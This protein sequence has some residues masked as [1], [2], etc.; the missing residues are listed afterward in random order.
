[1]GPGTRKQREVADRERLILDVAA[2][3]LVE[4]G[5]LGLT[6]DRIAEATEYSK[7]T[8]YQHFPNKEDI[9]AQLAI[10]T[11][12]RRAALFRRAA[13]FQGNS[14]ER[15]AA[16][17][18]A[19]GLF[20]R[21]NPLHSRCEPMLRAHSIREKTNPDRLVRLE[22]CEFACMDVALGVV[23]E[24]MAA[25][26]LAGD[27]ETLPQTIMLGLWALASGFHALAIQED[28]DLESKLGISDPATTLFTCYDHL[29]DGFGWKP[30]STEWDYAAT[31]ERVRREV[32]PDEFQQA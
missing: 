15:M 9:L 4:R 12:E 8:I 20:V 14:R 30:L 19:E 24:G 29:L 6:M 26:D 3:M 13:A 10:E 1:M 28:K 31:H 7:G 17:G 25:G 32:F 27:P 2:G 21:L 16:I 18:L 5:Y 23:R 11:T 22:A